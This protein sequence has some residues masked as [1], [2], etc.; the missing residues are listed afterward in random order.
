MNTH[1]RHNQLAIIFSFLITISLITA[2][3]SISNQL[4]FSSLSKIIFQK[5]S[6][7]RIIEEGDCGDQVGYH[8]DE[9]RGCIK[10]LTSSSK[11]PSPKASPKDFTKPASPKPPTSPS[12]SSASCVGGNGAKVPAGS[13]ASTGYGLN[14]NGKRCTTSG[15]LKRECVRCGSNGEWETQT[16]ACD[17]KYKKDPTK[18]VLPPQPGYEY[19]QGTKPPPGSSGS[20]PSAKANCYTGNVIHPTGTL[21]GGDRCVNGEWL[22]DKSTTCN[23]TTQDYDAATNQCVPKQVASVSP[24]ASILKPSPN[25]CGNGFTFRDG[26]CD[27]NY[28]GDRSDMMHSADAAACTAQGLPYDTNTGLCQTPTTGRPRTC[29]AGTVNQ[30]GTS[31]GYRYC[32]T[33]PAG[34]VT[35]EKYIYC[36]SAKNEL[37]DS[38]IGTCK[39]VVINTPTPV[40]VSYNTGTSLS[41]PINLGTNDLFNSCESCGSLGCSPLTGRCSEPKPVTPIN[42]YASCQS[43][44]TEAAKLECNTNMTNLQNG[45]NFITFGAFNPYAESFAPSNIIHT[46][47]HEGYATREACL[48]VQG[49]NCD[50]V[51]AYTAEQFASSTK[52][53]TTLV[54]EGAVIASGVGVVTGGTSLAVAGTQIVAINALSQTGTAVDSCVL[55]PGSQKCIEDAAWA[56][57]SVAN[58]GSIGYAANAAQAGGQA[59][60]TA[61]I[62]NGTVSGAEAIGNI[63]Q[64]GQACLGDEATVLGCTITASFS[65]IHAK[66][67][68]ADIEYALTSAAKKIAD[69]INDAIGGALRG[70]DMPDMTTPALLGDTHGLNSS[71]LEQKLWEAEITDLFG[72]R[73]AKPA[74]IQ[75]DDFGKTTTLNDSVTPGIDNLERILELKAAN[76]DATTLSLGNWDGARVPLAVVSYL[77]DDQATLGKIINKTLSATEVEI[78]ATTPEVLA[79]Q[80]SQAD[81]VTVMDDVG[82]QHIDTP[83]LAR[84]SLSADDIAR[85]GKTDSA[86]AKQLT[87][88]TLNPAALTPDS[89]LT[90]KKGQQLL[91]LTPTNVV[92]NINKNAHDIVTNALLHPEIPANVTALTLL[93]KVMGSEGTF[94]GVS[95]STILPTYA[96]MIGA[97]NLVHGHNPVSAMLAGQGSVDEVLKTQLIHTGYTGIYTE[98]T[99]GIT[100]VNIDADLS[101]LM[102]IPKLFDDAGKQIFLP[103]IDGIVQMPEGM[104]AQL[105]DIVN[106]PQSL[107]TF[108]NSLPTPPQAPTNIKVLK[109]FKK[110]LSTF[111]GGSRSDSTSGPGGAGN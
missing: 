41:G 8:W 16:A 13:W 61:R 71:Q 21:Q 42:N 72:K 10:N 105:R 32:E 28:A 18:V 80:L 109:Y 48:V 63:Y 38:K 3:L 87:D 27:D 91:G 1:H 54:A 14:D 81:F 50:N 49:D 79:R 35:G 58:V 51:A 36:D 65:I 73:T 17:E 99:S 93:D 15:C 100:L 101:P 31:T 89:L 94:Y 4:K 66:S 83:E 106:V 5:A 60:N 57:L 90:I 19:T 108:P 74:Y 102:R 44:P 76:P 55:E 98:P 97:N 56:L 103:Q 86:L 68:G 77:N 104:A 7:N 78:L 12:P 82:I 47:Q 33:D 22:P 45:L 69:P 23:S 25:P 92:G 43:E 37:Y 107:P 84:F 24:P 46:W 53:G 52:L 70:L 67:T 62:I 20:D 39:T 110:I 85:I 26:F 40:S 75:L 34:K 95:R 9:V 111:S 88:I 59:L 2:S 30:T 11:A 6:I 64:T 29:T 96:E